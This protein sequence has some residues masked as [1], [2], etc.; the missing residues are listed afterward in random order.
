MKETLKDRLTSRKFLLTV[1]AILGAVSAG[2]TGAMTW[3]V[4]VQTCVVAIVPFILGQSYIEGKVA[5]FV[6]PAVQQQIIENAATALANKF[7]GNKVAQVT[8]VLSPSPT[9]VNT[10]MVVKSPA[11]MLPDLTPSEVAEALQT[12]RKNKSLV[13]ST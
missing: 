11:I 13:S 7:I 2:L 1:A 12:A 5:E 10:P 9:I 8:A 3:P 4:V 6:P